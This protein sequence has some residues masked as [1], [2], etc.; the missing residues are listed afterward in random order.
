MKKFYRKDIDFLRAV[1][2]IFVILYHYFPNL[3]SKGYLGVDLFFVISGFLISHQIY[4]Q[5]ILNNFSLKE[6]YIRRM[7]RILPATLF[8]LILIWIISALLMTNQDY[9]SFL[10]SLVFSL[11]FSSNFFFWLDGGY[12]GPNDEIKPL[13]HLWS[14]GIEEQFYIIFPIVFTILI[15]YLKNIN[16]L[17]L[18]VSLITLLSFILNFFLIKIGG[19]NPAFF[20]LPTRVWNLAFGVLAMLIFVN[21]KKSHSNF[22]VIFL[23]F[24]IFVGFF[25]ELPQVPTNLLLIFACFML[26]RKTIPQNFI[27]KNIIENKYLNYLGLISFSLYLWHWPILVFFKYYYVYEVSFFIKILS[28]FITFALAAFSYHI[29]ELNFRYRINYKKLILSMAVIYSFLIGVFIHQNTIKKYLNFEVNSPDF[30]ASA[31]LTNFKCNPKYFFLYNKMKG[32][33]LNK[34]IKNEYN[35][36]IIGNSH[37]QMYVPSILPF[38]KKKSE[39]AILLPMTG[40]LP[41][42]TININESCLIKS[43]SYFKKYAEDKQIKKVLIATTWWHK[44][45]YNG[46]EYITDKNHLLLANSLIDLI[47][48]LENLDKDVYLVGPIQVPLYELPQ[49]L[50]RLLKFNHIDKK[51]VISRLKEERIIYENSYKEVNKLLSKKLGKNFINL[52]HKLCDDDHC[53]YADNE[54][55]YFADGSHLSYYASDLLSDNFRVIFE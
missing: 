24:L 30:I 43:K 25:Y 55:V 11:L 18:I 54:G 13:L 53:Y 7:K 28:L 40:C 23:I 36:A 52:S 33:V 38:L 31:S 46:D 47:G 12:F 21:N 32:C 22:E 44:N 27:F 41:T 10:K 15:K 1:A 49:E 3:I 2:V 42:I 37:A 20:L 50:S 16:N 5:K 45:I 19:S 34:T 48:R 35:L 39:K 4:N 17:I 26:L 6:F 14:L 51:Q 9:F 29:V 8:L